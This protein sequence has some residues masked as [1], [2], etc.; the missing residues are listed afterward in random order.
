MQDDLQRMELEATSVEPKNPKPPV[1]DENEPKH[2]HQPSLSKWDA[3]SYASDAPPPPPDHEE[4]ANVSAYQNEDRLSDRLKKLSVDSP[5]FSPFP[6]VTGDNVPPGD[7]AKEEILWKARAHVLHSQVISMQITWARDVLIWAEISMDAAARDAAA[8][9]GRPSTPRIE[10][11]LRVDAMNI[12]NHLAGQEHPDALYIRSKWLE[13]GKF[14]NRVDKRD[15]YSGYQ[16]AA[17]LG[18]AR[19]EYRMGMLFEQSNE[20]AKAK[21]HYYQGMRLKDSAALYRMGMMNLLGQH[22]EGKDYPGGLE[23]IRQAADSSDED[24]PQ[25]AYVYGM[26]IARDLPDINLPEG[27]L[28]NNLETARMYIEK[29]AYQGF[30]KAQLKMGQAFELCQLGCEFNPSYSLHYYG[31]AAKQGVPEAALGVSRWF[32]FGYEGVFKK[33]EELAFKY[34]QEA[35]AAKLPTGEFAMGY[36]YEIGIHATKSVSDARKWYQLAAEHGNTDAVGRLESLEKDQTLSKKDHETTTL[37][38]IKSQYGSQRGQRPE[39]FKQQQPQNHMPTVTEQTGYYSGASTPPTEPSNIPPPAPP[40]ASSAG[41]SPQPSPGLNA[42][43]VSD[44][45]D[46]P[47]PSKTTFNPDRTPAFNIRLD[48]GSSQGPGQGP[49]RPVSAAPY[50]VD[51]RPAP[52]AVSRPKSTAPYPDDEPQGPPAQFLNSRPNPGIQADRPGSAFGI[53]PQVGGPRPLPASYS[54]GNLQPQPHQ[55]PPRGRV[56]SAGPGAYRQPS[57]GPPGGPPYDN[58][59]SRP[60]SAAPYPVTAHPN[61]QQPNRLQKTQPPPRHSQPG[62]YPHGP[63]DFGP[64]TSSRPQSS[65][66]GPFPP[67]GQERMSRVPPAGAPP[68]GGQTRP[69]PER[70]SSMPIDPRVSRISSGMGPGGPG[71]GPGSGSRPGSAAPQGPPRVGTAPAAPAGP[72]RPDFSSPAPSTSSAPPR[73]GKVPAKQGPATF[74][75]MGI[76]QGKQDGDCVSYPVYSVTSVTFC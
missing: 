31:L 32:L 25:G 45:V 6:K 48:P 58:A 28:S 23:R 75:D 47:D 1:N 41:P 15:A 26:L 44:S 3:P 60:M 50:P 42:T 76:P 56:V 21:E 7:D 68:P 54:T 10:H 49:P 4:P 71:P 19:S 69:A 29:A 37:T 33:N 51:D 34:A 35:A 39:R 22:G 43:R 55:Q 13:F 63:N 70:F 2:A 62:G 12:I 16:K 59:Q 67:Q 5:S 9:K 52:L 73:P 57:P 8:G 14:G 20:I 36:Y 65:A 64:R 38:R 61:N 24:A 66:P 18:N 74:E 53:K 30:A 46:F 17:E 27:L 72:P 11:E 40:H